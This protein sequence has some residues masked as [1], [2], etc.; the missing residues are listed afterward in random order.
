MRGLD[1]L[2]A[3][4][5]LPL[6]ALSCSNVLLP[7]S[8]HGVV[9]ARTMD[10]GSWSDFELIAH[11]PAS[12]EEFG[13][14]GVY[15]TASRFHEIGVQ[16]GVA[17]GMNTQGLSCDMQT[18][19]KTTY[20]DQPTPDD[21]K[22]G[23]FVAFVC[24][25]ALKNFQTT[26]DVKD[27]LKNTHTVWGP[28]KFSFD[29][30]FSFRDANGNSIVV[31]FLDHETVIS[32]DK[33]DGKS[34]FGI[35]TNEP[36]YSWHIENVKHYEWKKG[37]AA[38]IIE[39]PGAFYPDHRFIRLHNLK[40][41]LEEPKSNKDLIMNAVHLLNSVTIPPGLIM[42][43]DS[44]EGEGEGD[45]TI[46]GMVYDHTENVVYYRSYDNQ[47]LQRVRLS[48]LGLDEI[49]GAKKFLPIVND[50][51]WFIDSARSFRRIP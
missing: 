2:A 8:E 31:E 27:A 26:K 24:E 5:A 38:P 37:L 36:P 9:H 22:E 14:L 50:Q 46:F 40:G 16:M 41:G 28:T 21:D 11:P 18:L 15:P 23:V 35:M 20:P 7:P 39:A 43:T 47:S 10:L 4:T 45:H 33:N 3:L 29:Q 44:G 51:K 1:V 49:G 42:G 32:E 25:W 48:D 13:Y 34:G 19:L 17:A 30:H 6:C 12:T